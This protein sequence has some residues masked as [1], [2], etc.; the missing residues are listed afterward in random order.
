MCSPNLLNQCNVK[1]NNSSE[2]LINIDRNNLYI[3]KIKFVN[4]V[5]KSNYFLKKFDN[6]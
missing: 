6:E 1:G 5:R 2:Q 3:I 4:N